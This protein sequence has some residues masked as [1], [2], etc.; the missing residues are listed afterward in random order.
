VITAS[1]GHAWSPA[2]S[3]AVLDFAAAHARAPS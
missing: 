1:G 2:D 3:T